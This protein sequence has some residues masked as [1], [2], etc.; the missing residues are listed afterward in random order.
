ISSCSKPTA[1]FSQSSERKEF[2]HM[3][4]ARPSPVWAG[5][6][7]TGRISCR[8]TGT[9]A[10]AICQAA[11]E[12]ARPPPTTWMGL[13]VWVIAADNR[14][15]D[16]PSQGGRYAGVFALSGAVRDG[17]DAGACG[18]AHQEVFVRRQAALRQGSGGEELSGF[19][20]S[21]RDKFSGFARYE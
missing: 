13:K 1:L 6:I 3:S 2:E 14:D 19:Q 11:S 9:P 21:T 17:C 7:F 10:L 8:T 4:S 20:S 18:G 16:R 15:G 12:P 5:V